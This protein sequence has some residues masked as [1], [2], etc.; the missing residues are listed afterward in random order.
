MVPLS[1]VHIQLRPRITLDPKVA[2]QPSER[3]RL[4][5]AP[6]AQGGTFAVSP[7]SLRVQLALR[8]FLR[9]HGPQKFSRSDSAHS[10]LARA[11]SNQQG[12]PANIVV[13]CAILHVRTLS[14][15]RGREGG[16][17]EQNPVG[18]SRVGYAEWRAKSVSFLTPSR[19]RRP[20]PVN[21]GNNEYQ[22]SRKF[23]VTRPLNLSLRSDGVEPYHSGSEFLAYT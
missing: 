19:Y 11:S 5:A 12:R 9:T 22:R 18:V 14:T 4:V 17:N 20:V 13:Q 15:M 3:C 10:G 7:S 2:M 1:L 21:I 8:W 23:S 6:R 16:P